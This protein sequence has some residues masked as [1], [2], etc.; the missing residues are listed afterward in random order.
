MNTI[1]NV[2]LNDDGTFAVS[3]MLFHM[4]GFWELYFDIT[5]GAVTERAQDEI[6]IE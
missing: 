1:P 5:E 2:R 4:P 3:E 6:D